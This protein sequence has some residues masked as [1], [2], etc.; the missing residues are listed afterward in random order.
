[1]VSQLEKGVYI[2]YHKKDLR[3]AIDEIFKGKFGLAKKSIGG[4]VS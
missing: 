4:R 3:I 2:C 1:M